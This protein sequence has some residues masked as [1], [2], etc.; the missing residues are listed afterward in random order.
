M[1]NKV[2]N[3][4]MFMLEGMAFT[5]RVMP[6][7]MINSLLFEVAFLILAVVSTITLVVTFI[8][9]VGFSFVYLIWAIILFRTLIHIFYYIIIQSLRLNVYLYSFYSELNDIEPFNINE[10]LGDLLGKV[11]L[12]GGLVKKSGQKIEPTGSEGAPILEG[13]LNTILKENVAQVA[14]A[15]NLNTSEL[16]G[17][18][19]QSSEE[20]AADIGES[21]QAIEPEEEPEEV[22]EAV[23]EEPEPEE[24]I[25]ITV[26]DIEVEVTP[27]SSPF[28]NANRVNNQRR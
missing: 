12:L 13:D 28:N 5:V 3:Q 22:V 20:V 18:Q 19:K 26:E 17:N 11:P 14:S 25:D 2:K 7:L 10:T 27:P 9:Y 8:G 23:A 1:K 15:F 16:L 24:E 4:A 21:V 6:Q